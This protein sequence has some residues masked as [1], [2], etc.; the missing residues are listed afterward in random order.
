MQVED[1]R[2]LFLGTFVRPPEETAGAARVEA[3]VHEYAVP[4]GVVLDD[5]ALWLP[6]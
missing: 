1:V 3:A 2:R 6:R 5:V 4:R